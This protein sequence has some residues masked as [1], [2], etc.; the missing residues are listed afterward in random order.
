MN[1][2]TLY[3]SIYYLFSRLGYINPKRVR[4]NNESYRLLVQFYNERRFL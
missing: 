2:A 3:S 4:T 1:T